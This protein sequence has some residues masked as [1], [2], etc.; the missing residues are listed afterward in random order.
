MSFIVIQPRRNTEAGA[1][2]SNP[3]LAVGERGFETDTRR[4]KTG[5]GSTN[6]NDLPY[7]SE[8]GGGAT[9]LGVTRNATS[10]TVVATGDDAVLPA[11]D[12][13]N[14]GVMTAAM[15]A[16]LS[17]VAEG[18]TANASDADLRD[19]STHT[20]TQPSTTIS[21][22]TEAVQDAVAALLAQGTNV[23][24]TYDDN[25]NVLTISA[26]GAGGGLDAEGVRDTIGV[27]LQ[28]VGN[29]SVVANDAGDTITVS[30][31][32][33]V[34]AT[35]AALR[36][37]STH[38]GSQAASTISDF[39]TATDARITAATG[40][41]VQG[42]NAN[43]T[44]LGNTTTGTGSIV[45]SASPTF[46]GTVSGISKS[47]VGLGNVDNTADT[48]KPVSTATQTALDGKQPLD[49]ELT[50]IA[51]L[52]S[53]ANRF[54]YF[55]GSGTAALADITAAGRA[56]IDDAD[57]AAMRATLGIRNVVTVTNT[58][59]PSIAAAPTMVLN[60]SGL[61]V[62]VTSVSVTGSPLDGDRVLMRFKDDGTSR[63]I[64][65]GASF[66]AMGVTVPT[67]TTSG[68]WLQIGAVYNAVDSIWDV[69]A[70]GVQ[71]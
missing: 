30:T 28:G 61:A 71:A 18:A 5:D 11:A 7:D 8:G 25:G 38:T 68:K 3:V 51:G 10:V 53:A 4:W 44:T 35:D 40:V 17:G 23:T 56:L 13:S 42:F 49:A 52:T 70:V 24:L 39:N 6:W 15:Q 26:S 60:D 1:A 69:L 58:A 59:A 34:N 31:T 2:E 63:T 48:A 50:A 32:A 46:T 14:A 22:F 43:T 16:K 45:R 65:L 20:G 64:T 36:D 37:R 33:T 54:P 27:A 55:T 12:G 21:D 62:A 41:T 67:A 29:V 47:M 66:R 57:A 19:R 9:D